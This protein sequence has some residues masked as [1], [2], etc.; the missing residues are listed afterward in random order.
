LLSFCAALGTAAGCPGPSSDPERSATRL[1]MAKDFLRKGNLEA[2][3]QEANRSLAYAKTNEEAENVLGLV[4]LLRGLETERLVEVDECLTGV[5]AEV[6]RGDLDKSLESADTHFARAA[7][8]APDF[9]EALANRGVVAIQL[10][11]HE[12]AIKYLTEA[13]GLPARLIDI[14]TVRANLGWAYFH[15]ADYVRAA[16]E[17]LQAYQF[18]PGGCVATYRLGRVYFARKEWEKASEKFREVSGQSGCPLQEADLYLMKSLIELDGGVGS[19]E[20]EK[21]RDACLSLSPKS[22]I[23]AQCR[24]LSRDGNQGA[25]DEVDRSDSARDATH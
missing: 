2:A 12:D 9:G 16:K 1:E 7:A 15:A 25:P 6:L 17:L 5:D 24:S 21:A 22:C 14:G 11:N 23:A 8:L 13:L 4:F 19:G 20:I 18:R 10:G 3:E